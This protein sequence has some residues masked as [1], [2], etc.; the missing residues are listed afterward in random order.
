MAK[1]LEIEHIWL[2]IASVYGPYDRESTMIN[3]SIDAMLKGKSPEY[4]KAE[5]TWDYL[6]AE[7]MA[8]ALYLVCEKGKKDSI[9]CVGSGKQRVLREYIEE[10]RS[11]VNPN[12]KLK[13]GYKDYSE[14][15]VMNLSVDISDL[16]KDTGFVPEIDFEEGI[17]RT[18]KWHKEKDIKR[19]DIKNEKN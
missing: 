1:L 19:D 6:Y 11:Q 15:Q 2:R 9:Y 8:R 10:I 14:N 18:I 12:L 13:I 5:Q 4:T 7:D 17:R 3:T 16:T